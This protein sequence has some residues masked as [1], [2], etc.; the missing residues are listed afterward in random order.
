MSHLTVQR[1]GKA[2]HIPLATVQDVIDLMDANYAKNRQTLLDDLDAMNASEETK[3]KAMT[4]MRERKGMTTDLIR[5][6]FTLPGARAILEHV[7]RP[8][9]HEAIFED[10]PD[11]IVQIALEVLGFTVDGDDAETAGDTDLN[12][13]KGDA[14][15]IVK[16]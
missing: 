15:S 6:A 5:E 13:Q 1:Q 3:L 4:E 12:P 11:K 7:A 14:T 8:E 16:P 10:A 2:Y 9:D